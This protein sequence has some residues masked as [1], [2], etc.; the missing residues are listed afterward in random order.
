MCFSVLLLVLFFLC[1]SFLSNCL[2]STYWQILYLDRL[3]R[4]PIQWGVFPR[5]KVWTMQQIG[6]AAKSDKLLSGDYG[7][8]GVS[9]F[10]CVLLHS[11]SNKYG[12]E[13]SNQFS[14]VW[15]FLVVDQAIGYC[16]W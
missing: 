11:P 9:T 8:L 14:F 4:D 15:S 1:G 12:V 6:M 7:K 2:F 5:I 10:V 3:D 13:R 16:L